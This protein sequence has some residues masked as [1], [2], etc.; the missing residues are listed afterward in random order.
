M[1]KCARAL[2]R[3]PDVVRDTI[4]TP[5]FQELLSK[6]ESDAMARVDRERSGLDPRPPDGNPPDLWDSAET[7]IPQSILVRAAEVIQ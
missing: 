2:H 7:M 1:E 5:E 3:S 4:A 6:Y